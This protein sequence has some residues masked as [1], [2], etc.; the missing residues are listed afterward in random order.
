M[1]ARDFENIIGNGKVFNSCYGNYSDKSC[2]YDNDLTIKEMVE[3]D[4][5]REIQ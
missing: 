1:N 3:P 2:G 4:F 5:S